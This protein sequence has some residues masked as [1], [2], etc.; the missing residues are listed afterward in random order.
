MPKGNSWH[1]F[2][3]NEIGQN[4]I[5]SLSFTQ[6]LNIVHSLNVV[7]LHKAI[8]YV[9][10]FSTSKPT[11]YE[12]DRTR[13]KTATASNWEILMP[14]SFLL[15]KVIRCS[16]ARKHSVSNYTSDFHRSC[17]ELIEPILKEACSQ[18][19]PESAIC[20]QR[21]D[22]SRNSAIRI[23]YRISLRSSSLHDP[24]YPLLR[25][26]QYFVKLINHRSSQ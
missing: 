17:W 4:I 7:D 22:D 9:I 2:F 19:Y 6:A 24:R 25:V 26:V 13:P 11:R 8:I 1:H 23:T 21:F 15:F 3:W 14:I 10:S 20:V 16:K 18:A 5:T 12:L